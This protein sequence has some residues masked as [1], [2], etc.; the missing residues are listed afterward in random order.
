MQGV[1][2]RIESLGKQVLLANLLWGHIRK[3]LPRLS[4][5]ELD[6]NPFLHRLGAVHRNA[7][8]G[9]ITQIVSL[10]E[11]RHVLARDLRLLCGQSGEDRRERLGD[12]DRHVAC[13]AA[14]R[15]LRVGEAERKDDGC[16]GHSGQKSSSFHRD[17]GVLLHVT[18]QTVSASHTGD[19]D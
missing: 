2:Q 12:G 3:S 14:G 16:S 7:C 5:R 11:K 6:A 8:G 19:K 9:S 18:L 10:V 17:H 4:R 1:R 15:L 13:L